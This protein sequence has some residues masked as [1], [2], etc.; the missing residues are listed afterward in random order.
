MAFFD[1]ILNQVYGSIPQV[2]NVYILA[3]FNSLLHHADWM[4]GAL[5]A[6]RRQRGLRTILV[7]HPNPFEPTTCND[8]FAECDADRNLPFIQVGMI[9]SDNKKKGLNLLDAEWKCTA[10]ETR[11]QLQCRQPSSFLFWVKCTNLKFS[12][13]HHMF[14]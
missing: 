13:C 9:V 7:R 14:G 12:V 11:S 1:T 3:S 5:N 2:A 4:A 10:Y 6:K 8:K